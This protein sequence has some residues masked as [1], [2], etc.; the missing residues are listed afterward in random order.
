MWKGEVVR[1]QLA[2][3]AA[4]PMVVTSELTA[5]AGKGIEGDRYSKGI[6][7]FSPNKGPHRQVTLF[8]SEVLETL[9][10]DHNKDLTPSECRMNLIT[11]GVPLSH[12][13]GR[14]FRAGEVTLRGVKLNEP[15]QHLEDV[16]SK[17]VIS[18]LVHRCGLFAEVLESGKI[19]PG[20]TVQSI[21]AP[22]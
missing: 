6:G 7:F 19:R 17:S 18:C 20:D 13:V 9:K 8:E 22:S 21:E 11:R 14:T 2:P 10:R 15:C 3:E 12:L 16:V 1:T 4:V 5:I